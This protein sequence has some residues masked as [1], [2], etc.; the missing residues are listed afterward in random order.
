MSLLGR[1]LFYFWDRVSHFTPGQPGSFGN[2]P[3][4]EPDAD[5]IGHVCPHP[6][7]HCFMCVPPQCHNSSCMASDCHQTLPLKLVVTHGCY[8][9]HLTDDRCKVYKVTCLSIGAIQI[10]PANSRAWI[11]SLVSLISSSAC[12][13]TLTL[14]P[15]EAPPYLLD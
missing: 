1:S 2:L 11:L 6:A 13:L 8:Q 9:I 12:G 7:A 10:H 5:I 3:A 4:L 14:Q 15:R